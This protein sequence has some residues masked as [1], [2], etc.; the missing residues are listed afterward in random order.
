[1][2]SFSRLTLRYSHLEYANS[3]WYPKRKN[4]VDKL[5]RVQKTANKLILELSKQ[6]GQQD[7]APPNSGYWPTSEPNAG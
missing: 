3:V 7:S 5:E 2:H 4:V 6:E 1:M